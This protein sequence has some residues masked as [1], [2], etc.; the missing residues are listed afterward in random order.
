VHR[1]FA[2]LFEKSINYTSVKDFILT[3]SNVILKNVELFDLF[4]SNEMGKD[5]K[6]MAFNLEYYDFERT[7]TDEEVEK[8]FQSL[9]SKVENNFNAIL[10]GK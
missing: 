9:I 5:K 8:D 2:F 10:R 6:S 3:E 1:D 4:E 7:L